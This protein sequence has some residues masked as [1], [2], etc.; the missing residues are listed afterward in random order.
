MTYI[1]SLFW[2]Y[3]EKYLSWLTFT[4]PLGMSCYIEVSIYLSAVVPLAAYLALTFITKSLT[5]LFQMIKYCHLI[6]VIFVS[7]SSQTCY[8]CLHYGNQSSQ[9]F[10]VPL[11]LIY[12][13]WL[14]LLKCPIVP[15]MK[16]S[17]LVVYWHFT[18]CPFYHAQLSEHFDILLYHVR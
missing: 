4:W 1:F 6:L 18:M 10:S 2:L 3:R 13:F 9:D 12:S 15:F 11:S 5:T 14:H 7:C 8:L 17:W 16:L